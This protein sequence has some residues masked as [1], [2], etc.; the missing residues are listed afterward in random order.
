MRKYLVQVDVF[1][2]SCVNPMNKDYPTFHQE[3]TLKLGFI[4]DSNLFL[5]RHCLNI[6]KK[7]SRMVNFIFTNFKTRN[8]EF[9]FELYKWYVTPLIHYWCQLYFPFIVSKAYWKYS[10][11]FYKASLQSKITHLNYVNRFKHFF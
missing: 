8:V 9:L 7:L 2:Q 4:V 6:V 11:S 10:K 3:T 5:D 1:D